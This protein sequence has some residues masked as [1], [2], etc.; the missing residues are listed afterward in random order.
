MFDRAKIIDQNFRNFVTNNCSL[1]GELFRELSSL[2]TLKVSELVDIYDTQIMSRQLD[3]WSRRSKGKTFYSIG[4]SGHE[5]L[6]AIGIASRADDMAFLHYRDAAFLIQ[7]RKKV[8]GQNVLYDMAL[9]FAASSHDP[10]SGGRH[11]VLGCAA[12]YVPPQ[13]STIASHLPKAVGAAHSIGMSR[14]KDGIDENNAR[15]LQ[16]D[17]VI[18]CSF[19]DASANHSTAQGAINAACWAAYQHM[20]MPIV[21]ICE[22]NGIGI[23]VRTPDGWT[24]QNYMNRPG[25]KYIAANGLDIVDA[26]EKSRQAIEYARVKQKP[27]FLHIKT[28]RLMGHAGAD[29]EA[30]YASSKFI[31]ER[32]ALDPL[33]TT[34]AYLA[35]YS[36]LTS[37]DI[38]RRYD[39]MAERVERVAAQALTTPRLTSKK[40]IIASIIPPKKPRTEPTS[41]INGAHEIFAKEQNNL[42]KPATIA[43][44]INW[45]LAE[46]MASNQNIAIFGEDV[47]RKG[48]VYGVTQGLMG[49]FGNRRVFDTLLDEQ[50]ILG[51]AIGMGHN[52][53]IPVP[54]IQFLAYL[55]NAEDQIRGEAATLSY[56]SNG[57]YTNPMVVRI[58]GLPYQKGFGGHFHND[59]SLAVLT[60]IPGIIIA[61]PSTP[62]DAAAMMREAIR[63]AEEEQRVVVMVEPI[64]LYHQQDLHEAG[65]GKWAQHYQFAGDA[66]AASFGDI[67]IYEN[68]NDKPSKKADAAIITY[69]NGHYLSRQAQKI[70]TENHDISVKIIDVRWLHP[71]PEAAIINAVKDAKHILIVDEGRQSGGLNEKFMTML[72]EHG[73][74]DKSRRLCAVDCFI[75]LGPAA[76]ILLPSRDD[77]IE[78]ILKMVK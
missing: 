75:P 37:A 42:A 25:L 40:D 36:Y 41:Q 20:A 23:S 2:G 3:F 13:T 59:N 68:N 55:H 35:K 6:A 30:S 7:R 38:L 73:L 22:D 53:Y 14:R 72:A 62:Q 54:E 1:E 64:A 46:M 51:L 21:F 16:Q 12:S 74:A 32:E 70:L 67:A 10:I 61:C 45:A 52:G 17:G 4:S 5:G 60:D 31:E 76:E 44:S 33:L 78:N 11:K 28:V 18:L 8:G 39:E 65:D 49:K 47:A 56:F 15:I 63:L 27:V 19:G 69:G 57:Q 66:D 43:K 50:T 58:A 48:G 9:S 26:V 77:I 24:A 29:V 34:A 71:L